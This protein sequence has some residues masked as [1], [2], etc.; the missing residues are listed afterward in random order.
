[1][2]AVAIDVERYM[3]TQS[4]SHHD[5]SLKFRFRNPLPVI[6][7]RAVFLKKFDERWIYPVFYELV[8]LPG[9]DLVDVEL[10]MSINKMLREVSSHGNLHSLF[11]A[12]SPPGKKL[13][14]VTAE[15]FSLFTPI[16]KFATFYKYFL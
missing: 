5:A 2:V 14:S 1:M 3:M 4:E 7:A 10:A 12:F 13:V 11:V 8:E 6:K 16:I 15:L 9:R